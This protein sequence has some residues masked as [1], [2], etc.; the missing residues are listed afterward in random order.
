ML[1]H[2]KEREPDAEAEISQLI[3]FSRYPI[4]FIKEHSAV[5]GFSVEKFLSSSALEATQGQ[6]ASSRRFGENSMIY[7]A[8]IAF[9]I[10][11][12]AVILYKHSV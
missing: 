7:N 4:E 12:A 6:R 5:V 3:C 11:L 9:I 10:A 1:G 2:D 8:L